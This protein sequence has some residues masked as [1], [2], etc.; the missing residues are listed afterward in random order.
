[1][2]EFKQAY[3]KIE[4]ISSDDSSQGSQ[5][6]FKNVCVFLTASPHICMYLRFDNFSQKRK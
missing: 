1:M 4:N 3:F 5:S 6:Y 2:I